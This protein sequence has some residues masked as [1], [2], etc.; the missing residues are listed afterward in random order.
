MLCSG[1]GIGNAPAGASN[2]QL[3]AQFDKLPLEKR[4]QV[5]MS[6]PGRHEDKVE[7]VKALYKAAG[8]EAPPEA[9]QEP[10]GQPQG[11]GKPP[12]KT[13]GG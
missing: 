8:Q 10:A 1:C 9:Y 11:A 5:I 7:K 3:K 12:T 2:D 13:A 6:F 4:A